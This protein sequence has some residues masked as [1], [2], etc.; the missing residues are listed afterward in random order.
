MNASREEPRGEANYGQ[1]FQT[2]DRKDPIIE[3]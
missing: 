2:G 1:L 3:R